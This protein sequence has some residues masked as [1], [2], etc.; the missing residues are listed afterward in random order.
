MEDF[1]D[2]DEVAWRI[3]QEKQF[4]SDIN[5]TEIDLAEKFQKA[6]NYS[7]LYF[8]RELSEDRL[9]K[10]IF[11]LEDGFKILIHDDSFP[12]LFQFLKSCRES[13]L[14]LIMNVYDYLKNLSQLLQKNGETE[15]AKKKIRMILKFCLLAVCRHKISAKHM[16]IRT[17]C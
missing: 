5:S 8:P 9:Q 11:V 14:L 7:K 13:Q 2:F 10:Y 12:K 1:Q 17:T 3:K 4:Y 6:V 15:K 16:T